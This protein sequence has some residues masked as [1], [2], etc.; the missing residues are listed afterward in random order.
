M[1]AGCSFGEVS[2]GLDWIR[3]DLVIPLE[4]NWNEN[5]LTRDA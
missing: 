5:K 4:P 3:I 1:T 2:L